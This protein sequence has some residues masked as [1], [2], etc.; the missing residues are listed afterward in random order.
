MTNTL[1][2]RKRICNCERIECLDGEP[3]VGQPCRLR[4]RH[5][6]RYTEI[7]TSDVADWWCGY[8]YALGEIRIETR[9]TVYCGRYAQEEVYA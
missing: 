7:R 9:N 3:V 1:T 6:D 5:G 8:P 2:N 4:L